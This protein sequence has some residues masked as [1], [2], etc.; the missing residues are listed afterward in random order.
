[1]DHLGSLNSTEH[2]EAMPLLKYSFV[3][4]LTSLFE[5]R[6]H[7]AFLSFYNVEPTVTA[8]GVTLYEGGGGW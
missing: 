3:R 7:N 2:H 4:L 6:R 8:T 1:M 5:G